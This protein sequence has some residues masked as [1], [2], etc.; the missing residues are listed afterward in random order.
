M[1]VFALRGA[2]APSALPADSA[3]GAGAAAGAAVAPNVALVGRGAEVGRLVSLVDMAR[4][5]TGGQ[6]V[7][8]TGGAGPSDRVL[9]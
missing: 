6:A 7:V 9:L 5:G 8:L 2:K 3:D 1:A 4:Q